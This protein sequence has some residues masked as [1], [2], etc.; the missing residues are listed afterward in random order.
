M[1]QIGDIHQTDRR[2]VIMLRSVEDGL[3][4]RS[5]TT[6]ASKQVPRQGTTQLA[7]KFVRS[8]LYKY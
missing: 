5:D 1:L 8:Y 6:C 4:L 7:L 3:S 2:A